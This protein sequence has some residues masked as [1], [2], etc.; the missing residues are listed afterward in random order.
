MRSRAAALCEV[1]HTH[2]TPY[3]VRPKGEFKPERIEERPEAG[4][5]SQAAAC[6]HGECSA[7]GVHEVW[8]AAWTEGRVPDVVCRK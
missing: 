6:G 5:T 2:R 8:Q 3:P 4:Q 1:A 7:M